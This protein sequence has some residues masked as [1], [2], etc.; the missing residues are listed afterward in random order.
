MNNTNGGIA[1]HNPIGGTDTVANV[2]LLDDKNGIEKVKH[3]V[4]S[5]SKLATQ[6]EDGYIGI[7][8][9]EFEI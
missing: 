3:Y 7:Y 5:R 6:D 4:A 9:M 8:D 1:K 2:F